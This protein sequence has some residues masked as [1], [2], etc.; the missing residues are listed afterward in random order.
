[1][2]AMEIGN[3]FVICGDCRQKIPEGKILKLEFSGCI[4]YLCPACIAK[5]HA[6]LGG[7]IG[8]VKLADEV[9]RIIDGICT[10]CG[11]AKKGSY[12]FLA[13]H[14]C[15]DCISK[16]FDKSGGESELRKICNNLVANSR[17][18]PHEETAFVLVVRKDYKKLKA[19]LLEDS[20]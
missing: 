9:G 14:I 6:L 18:G 2:R 5:A 3:S 20:K 16:A 12:E 19:A 17:L 10:E 4:H 13:G 8:A 11:E 15:R 7:E 1:M